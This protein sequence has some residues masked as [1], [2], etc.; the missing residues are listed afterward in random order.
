MQNLI[1]L[2][3]ST[4]EKS[5]YFIKIV[6]CKYPVLNEIIK[7]SVFN[8]IGNRKL[9]VFGI[10]HLILANHYMKVLD[11]LS[12]II[13]KEMSD[14]VIKQVLTCQIDIKKLTQKYNTVKDFREIHINK[15]Y[16]VNVIK[17]I[18]KYVKN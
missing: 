16:K 1:S 2:V 12:D 11:N 14:E 18:N 7:S 6:K 10:I 9:S 15:F 3:F 4:I 8:K 17:Q 5:E 13:A